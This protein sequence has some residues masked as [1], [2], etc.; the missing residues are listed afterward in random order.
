MEDISTYSGKNPDLLKIIILSF[1]RSCRFYSPVALKVCC[2]CHF[3]ERHL[4]PQRRGKNDVLHLFQFNCKTKIESLKR[5]SLGRLKKL[6]CYEKLHIIL[7]Y[8]ERNIKVP[9]IG[10]NHVT[11]KISWRKYP[12]ICTQMYQPVTK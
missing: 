11:L 5:K 1:T 9:G 7:R 12:Q 4:D 3:G 2:P 10:A 6:C 8:P